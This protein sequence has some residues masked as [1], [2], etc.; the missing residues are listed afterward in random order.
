M[1]CHFKPVIRHGAGNCKGGASWLC[2]LQSIDIGAGRLD[3][4]RII[5]AGQNLFIAESVFIG[6]RETRV[7]STNVSNQAGRSRHFVLFPQTHL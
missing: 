6:E 3:N 5:G 7:G 4:S 2:P 1:V